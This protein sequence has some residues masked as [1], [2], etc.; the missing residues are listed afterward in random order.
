MGTFESCARN[1]TINFSSTASVRYDLGA[2]YSGGIC[3]SEE[4]TLL[5]LVLLAVQ[6]SAPT[7]LLNRPV[8]TS[9]VQHL[10][11]HQLPTS[12]TVYPF[13]PSKR[14]LAMMVSL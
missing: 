10:V 1:G 6:E 11:V 2:E 4:F 12:W 8:P 13:V 3:S 7:V 9:V 14:K 5:V